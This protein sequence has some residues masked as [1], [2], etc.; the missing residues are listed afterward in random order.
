MFFP[1][2]K[3]TPKTV[4]QI[5]KRSTEKKNKESIRVSNSVFFPST[6][7]QERLEEKE[8]KNHCDLTQ[9]VSIKGISLCTE[10]KNYDSWNSKAAT[11]L[12]N[13]EILQ[14]TC[15][16]TT[17]ISLHLETIFKTWFQFKENYLEERK[18]F[19]II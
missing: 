3:V 19:S 15:I 11:L 1:S 5:L 9:L 7:L 17:S 12:A 8:L 14:R 2:L 10:E 6:N 16:K 4:C 13:K 18:T